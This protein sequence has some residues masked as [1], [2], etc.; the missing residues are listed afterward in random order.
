MPAATFET[1][2]FAHKL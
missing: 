2:H 1:L